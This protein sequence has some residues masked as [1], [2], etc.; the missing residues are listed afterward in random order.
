MRAYGAAAAL[1]SICT[2]AV[3]ARPAPDMEEPVHNTV[4][5]SIG[6]PAFE[7]PWRHVA[8]LPDM[9]VK[10]FEQGLNEVSDVQYE[11][12]LV[13][14]R[15]MENGTFY[16]FA[17]NAT[18]LYAAASG[19]SPYAALVY[20][21]RTE[22]DTRIVNIQAIGHSGMV[23]SYRAFEIP[24]PEAEASLKDALSDAA[25]IAS[26]NPLLTAIQIVA[27]RNYFFVGTISRH[28]IPIPAF[29]T[30]YQPLQDKARITELIVL[31]GED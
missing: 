7:E 14:R 23:G 9:T 5:Q 11:P 18:A 10:I 22:T 16:L 25:E 12:L 3:F 4:E 21:Y 13:T 24:A 30:V 26:F 1:F 2:A 15:N 27:G 8:L 19:A 20:L 17:C 29:I 6:I 28:S 31:S